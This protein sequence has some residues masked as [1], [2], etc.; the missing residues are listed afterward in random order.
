MKYSTVEDV[1]ASFP[2]PVLPAVQG[3]PNYQ[4]IHVTRQ[5]F[6]SNLKS[7]IHFFWRR[8]IG[9][10]GPHHLGCC[11]LPYSPNNEQRTETLGNT[12]SPRV[13]TSSDGWNISPNQRRSPPLGRGCP[14]LTYM[15]LRPTGIEE[16]DHQLV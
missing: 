13:G 10:L 14:N 11:I 4:T 16:A 8:H 5:F 6:P 2:H 12:T 1:M 15:H 9:T 3:E 7:N